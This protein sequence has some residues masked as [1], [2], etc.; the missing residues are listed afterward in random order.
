MYR[1]A[2]LQILSFLACVNLL[3]ASQETILYSFPGGTDA[4]NPTSNLIADSQGNLYGTTDFGGSVTCCGHGTVF[5]LTPP[6]AEGENWTE[7]VLYAF[8]GGT[9]GGEPHGGGLVFDQQGN[10][11]GTT[12]GGGTGVCPGFAGCGT[13]F[14]LSPPVGGVGSWTETVIYNF[15]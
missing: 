2:V 9:D 11:F 6:A 3:C 7:S 12:S 1:S 15:Q 4:A 10:L 13:V 8:T 14:E 5:K